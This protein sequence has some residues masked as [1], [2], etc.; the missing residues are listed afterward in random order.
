[1]HGK[2]FERTR[3]ALSTSFAR[4]MNTQSSER[5]TLLSEGAFGARPHACG[6]PDKGLR[7]GMGASSRY[8]N[9]L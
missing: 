5:D 4:R 9:A 1:M 7:K 6:R 8:H 2:N 3:L